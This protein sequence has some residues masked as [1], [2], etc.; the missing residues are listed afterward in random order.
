MRPG[1]LHVRANTMNP[2]RES[3]KEVLQMLASKENQ[4]KYEKD[5][6]VANVSSELICM[7]FDDIYHPDSSQHKEA[8]STE[9]Q[10]VLSSFNTFFY[11][12]KDKIPKTLS[13]M[14]ANQ[15]W[16]EIVKE[17]QRIIKLIEW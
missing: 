10:Q 6:P 5:V 2:I 17:A 11:S 13:E 9:E 1:D 12:R 15:L 7:W 16:N 4:I 8:F 14:H 3:L